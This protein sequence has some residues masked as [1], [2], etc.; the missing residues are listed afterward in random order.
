MRNSHNRKSRG[1]SLLELNLSLMVAAILL[2]GGYSLFQA[3]NQGLL[4][5]RDNNLAMWVLEGTRNRLLSEMI[6]F[7]KLDATKLQRWR[8]EVRLPPG[9]TLTS[10]IQQGEESDSRSSLQLNMLFSPETS[11]GRAR[12]ISRQ[13]VLNE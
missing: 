5:A 12:I 1:L 10:E 2:A 4:A 11:G 7:G 13:V 6:P 3:Q 8:E 9:I